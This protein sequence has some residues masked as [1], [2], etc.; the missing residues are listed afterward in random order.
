MNV[1]VTGATGVLGR[2]VAARL[3][4]RGHQVR[5]GTRSATAP[6]AA[7]ADRVVLDLFS[8]EGLSSA[9][10]GVDAVVHSASDPRRA[11]KVDREGTE[12]LLAACDRSVHVLYPSIVGCDVIPLRYY[13]AKLAAEQALEQ[14]GLGFTVIRAAQFHQLIWRAVTAMSRWPVVVVPAD[15][16]FQVIDPGV[17][18]AH[19]VEWVEAGPGGRL[20]DIGGPYAYESRDLARSVLTAIGSKRRTVAINAPGIVGAAFRAGGNTTE[21]RDTTGETWN[22][23]VERKMG[24]RG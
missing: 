21:N 6:V 5:A 14:W 23:F 19:L 4:E 7:G 10:S 11:K 1:L 16:R 13:E 12:R 2:R 8:G 9:V 3:V 15:T 24:E 18:A 17:V 22:E 20:P